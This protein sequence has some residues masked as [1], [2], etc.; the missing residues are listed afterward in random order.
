[1]GTVFWSLV[2]LFEVET[3][4]GL[5]VLE[6]GIFL[7]TRSL[8]WLPDGA[9]L[10]AS[11]GNQV[12]IF[13]VSTGKEVRRIETHPGTNYFRHAWS[14][15]GKKIA[16]SLVEQGGWWKG[17]RIWDADSGEQL[18]RIETFNGE[19]SW[20]PRGNL[21]A[22]L[23]DKQVHILDGG[24]GQRLRSWN[25]PFPSGSPAWSS[26][27][28]RIAIAAEKT[29]QIWAAA[30]GRLIHTLQGH[31]DKVRAIA[32]SPDDKTIAS[33]SGGDKTVRLWDA[34][35]GKPIHSF[36]GGDCVVLSWSPDGKSLASS[37]RENVRVWDIA[38]QDLQLRCSGV[39]VGWT[40]DS[41][42]VITQ[43][44]AAGLVRW[45]DRQS[46][47][48]LRKTKF[49]L[50]PGF[51]IARPDGRFAASAQRAC[52][53]IWEIDRGRTSLTLVPLRDGKWLAL[54]PDGHYRGSP[55]AEKELVYVVQTETGQ[56]L[57]AP[58]EF[59][60]KYGW[61]NDPQHVRLPPK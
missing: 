53:D 48:R 35:S 4:K 33:A 37:E 44:N 60:K 2:H 25:T 22:V 41:A 46:G 15:E 56:E 39:F 11:C 30:S 16:A 42:A 55:G 8:S 6:P 26:D 43:D 47:D 19:L 17:V 20:S 9:T 34:S 31:T 59:E 49:D 21:L 13:Q 52:L 57:L 40:A 38:A 29:V 7:E 50:L 5:R 14:S 24:S 28:Q 61:K 51:S 1:V 58:A 36:D 45:W 18:H 3:W 54:R 12:S 23:G 10:A 27:G 32:W